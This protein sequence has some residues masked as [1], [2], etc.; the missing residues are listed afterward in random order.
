MVYFPILTP[1]P[2]F[3]LE[4]LWLQCI[5]TLISWVLIGFH[6]AIGLWPAS[7]RTY[8]WAANVMAKPSVTRTVGEKWYH[9]FSR[10][11]ILPYPFSI[12]EFIACPVLGKNTSAV[13]FISI[14][15]RAVS[16]TVFIH[17]YT[18]FCSQ[19]T[20]QAAVYIHTLSG[21]LKTSSPGMSELHFLLTLV[22]SWIDFLQYCQSK[23][24]SLYN[25]FTIHLF[26]WHP[27]NQCTQ[28]FLGDLQLKRSFHS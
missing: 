1:D 2:L 10:Y 19:R 15:K 28:S 14:K 6:A 3:G 7:G 18:F 13:P 24:L 11:Y 16:F 12:S 4:L 20:S 8:W 17:L 9:A 5:L 25:I 23:L 26:V 27:K 21:H 22:Y